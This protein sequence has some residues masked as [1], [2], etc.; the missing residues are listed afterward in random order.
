MRRCFLRAHIVYAGWTVGIYRF[1][2]VPFLC[3]LGSRIDTYLFICALWGGENR[4]RI[5][6]K[7]LSTLLPVRYL[8][9]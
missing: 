9:W 5:N 8:C 6:I 4:I 7:F 3:R 2:W 1:R